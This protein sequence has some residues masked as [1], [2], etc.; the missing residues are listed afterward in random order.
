M[1]ETT[2]NYLLIPGSIKGRK[3]S[4][5]VRVS[6]KDAI[7]L[8]EHLTDLAYDYCYIYELND[9]YPNGLREVFIIYHQH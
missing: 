4:L 1:K 3:N 8:A 5:N 6:E 7:S 9:E 2:K